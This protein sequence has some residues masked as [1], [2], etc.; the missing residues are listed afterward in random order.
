[1][2]VQAQPAAPSNTNAALRYWMA[3]AMM[4]DPS[5]DE[6]TKNLL[7]AVAEG[8]A[9]WDEPRLGSL[10]DANDEAVRTMRRAAALPNCDWALEYELG[11][12]LPIAH[13]ARARVLARLNTLAGVRAMASGN[14]RDAIPIWIAGIRFAQHV[15]RGGSLLATLSGRAMLG[16]TM[17][18]LTRAVE[19]GRVDLAQRQQLGR[20]LATIPETGFDWGD[21]LEMERLGIEVWLVQLVK[22]PTPARSYQRAV[23]ASLPAGV[24]LP[25][26]A[27]ASAFAAFMSRTAAVLRLPPAVAVKELKSQQAAVQTLHPFY[28]PLIPS[29]ARIN[30]ARTQIK[31]ERDRLVAT[32]GP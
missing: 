23:G 5:T 26:S 4:Q 30:D 3:F 27:D 1:V 9:P 31:A 18:A 28:R 22:D 11:P 29:L 16:S 14:A 32:L 17:G 6:A 25:A 13:L 15:V 7:Q 24:S 2:S 10:L 19:E 12:E 8:R 21:A 20:V